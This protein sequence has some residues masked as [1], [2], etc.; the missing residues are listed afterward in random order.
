MTKLDQQNKIKQNATKLNKNKQAKVVNATE[1][2]YAI[3]SLIIIN[4]NEV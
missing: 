1:Y 4:N 2:L 3:K